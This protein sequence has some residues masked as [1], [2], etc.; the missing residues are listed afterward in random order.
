MGL[1]SCEEKDLNQLSLKLFHLI[2][3]RTGKSI[4]FTANLYIFYVWL[5]NVLKLTRLICLQSLSPVKIIT[6]F[7]VALTELVHVC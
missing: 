2:N 7:V 5:K 1:N 6:T 3:K 4:N